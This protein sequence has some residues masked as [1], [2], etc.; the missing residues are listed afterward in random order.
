[1]VDLEQLK[2]DG[3]KWL[4]KQEARVSGEAAGLSSIQKGR[5][6]SA[7]VSLSLTDLVDAGKQALD[8]FTSD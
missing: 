7:G 6:E 1:M 5:S 2:K 8:K 3:E 4:A